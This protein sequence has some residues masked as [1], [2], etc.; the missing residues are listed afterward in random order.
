MESI[1]VFF[2]VFYIIESCG[3]FN[4]IL[5]PNWNWWFFGSQIL[6]IWLEL[7]IIEKNQKV[8]QHWNIHQISTQKIQ[9]WLHIKEFSMFSWIQRWVRIMSIAFLYKCMLPHTCHTSSFSFIY[10]K[11][12]GYGTFVWYYT[13]TTQ[14]KPSTTLC[15]IFGDSLMIGDKCLKIR[16]VNKCWIHG[17]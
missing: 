5:C 6:M 12:D 3:S 7:T 14:Y 1:C 13:K 16:V 2:E 8:F 9:F 10:G 17:Y 11:R 4:L 15:W